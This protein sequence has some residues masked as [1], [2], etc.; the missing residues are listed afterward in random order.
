M[1]DNFLVVD[2]DVT[3]AGFELRRPDAGRGGDRLLPRDLSQGRSKKSVLET[4]D[5]KRLIEKRLQKRGQE[6][7]AVVGRTA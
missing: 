6:M 3:S 4:L 7:V 2:G 5:R 1:N